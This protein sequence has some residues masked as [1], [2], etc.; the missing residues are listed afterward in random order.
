MSES[1]PLVYVAGHRG[2]VGS[3]IARKIDQ[4]GEQRWIGRTRAE[5][6]LRDRTAVFDFLAET[7]P[8]SIVIAAAKVG[9]IAA[10]DAFP[11]EFLTENLLL[12][13]NLMDAAHSA[14]VEKVLF[15]G[16]SC[17]YPKF[18]AQ[19]IKE[20]SM[21]TGALEPTNDAYAI[22]KIA[23][24]RLVDAY[25]SEYGRQWISAMPTNIYGPGDNF[26]PE[27]SHVLPAL[28]RRFDEA[29]SSKSST[30]TLWGSGTALREFLFVD[31]LADAALFLLQRYNEPG[32]INVGFGEEISILDLAR[33][34]ADVTGFT[35]EI[36]WDSKRPNGT[37]RKLLDSSRL[38][39]LGWRPTTGLVEGIER[40]FD[41]LKSGD[42]RAVSGYR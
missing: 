22:A 10:N 25:R 26:D 31:D 34:I 1:T 2:L 21:L 33:L 18:A 28:L 40:T 24:I 13:S 42:G 4:R 20:S 39:G 36:A 12:Q 3:A 35:G 11:V 15:L 17:I 8:E 32:P 38:R 19:P 9:G 29:A 6:D 5:L 7:K 14:G 41:W 27:T 23:G 16:S 30:V 37:P